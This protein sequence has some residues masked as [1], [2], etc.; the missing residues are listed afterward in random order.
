VANPTLEEV[1]AAVFQ[2]G[3]LKAPGPDGFNGLFYQKSWEML[4]P[5]LFQLVQNFFN[6]GTLDP[7]INQTHISLI[8]KV[9]N[10]ETIGQF[11]P[12]SLCNFSY[13]IISKIL[14]N[15]LKKWLPD[16]IEPEQSAFVQ[17]RQI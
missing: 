5:D 12:I 14:A 13:K 16:I 3:A 8:P 15:R 9:K 7:L 11:R 1:H 4:K 6:T 17:G 10:P 2:L